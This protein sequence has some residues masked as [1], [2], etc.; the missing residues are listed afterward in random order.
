MKARMPNRG[1]CVGHGPRYRGYMGY[2]G[3]QRVSDEKDMEVKWK[4]PPATA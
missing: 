4:E 2:L 3:N 1:E